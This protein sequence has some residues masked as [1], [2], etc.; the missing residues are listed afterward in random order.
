MNE[1]VIRLENVSF[2]YPVDEGEPV[3][4]LDGISLEIEKGSFV[5]VLGK[6]GSGKSTL[7]KHL[8]ALLVPEEGDVFVHEMNTK[9]EERIW[10]IRS[11]CGMVFQN[12]DNQLIANIV[13]EDVAFGPENIGIETFV[14]LRLMNVVS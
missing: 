7:A 1:S 9:D 5:A 8:N 3:K 12:P 14:M 6:N 10:N 4:S 2:S 13:E 11:S